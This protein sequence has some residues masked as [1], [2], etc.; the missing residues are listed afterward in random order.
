MAT[1]TVTVDDITKVDFDVSFG[2]NGQTL[3]DV[4]S[5]T[6]ANIAQLLS[7]LSQANILESTY[8][9]PVFKDA[10]GNFFAVNVKN[11]FNSVVLD[12]ITCSSQDEADVLKKY[13]CGSLPTHIKIDSVR[14]KKVVDARDRNVGDLMV[15]L[16]QRLNYGVQ[17]K[18]PAHVSDEEEDIDRATWNTKV[19]THLPVYRAKCRTLLF[20]LRSLQKEYRKVLVSRPK[21]ETPAP[22]AIPTRDEPVQLHSGAGMQTPFGTS[23]HQDGSAQFGDGSF[24]LPPGFKLVM[25]Q[26]F[27][28]VA[29]QEGTE[30]R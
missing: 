14:S 25:I 17:R 9:D 3:G 18:D 1:A 12:F 29:V 7:A 11:F 24:P 23:W 21:R 15:T 28:P 30:F 8:I 6:K 27:G 26:G 16:V 22:K 19:R 4:A 13:T 5:M 20:N 10:L 2:Y